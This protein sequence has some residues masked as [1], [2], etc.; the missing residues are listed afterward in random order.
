MVK[1]LFFLIFFYM[2]GEVSAQELK[3]GYYPDGKLRYKGYFVNE[4]PVGELIRYYPEGEVKARM[5]YRGDTVEAVLYSRNGEYTLMGKFLK[6]R[7]FGVWEYRKES[8]VI[9]CEEYEND[10]LDGKSVK[11]D[12]NGRVLE[13]KCWKQGKRE[14]EWSLFYDNGQ[15]R[16]HTFY[17]ADHLNGEMKTYSRNGQ[18]RAK[19]LYKDNLK[20]G[21][22]EFYDE[23][24]HLVVQQVYHAGITENAELQELEESRKLDRLIDSGKKIPDP[25]VFMD[26]PD[27]YMRLTGME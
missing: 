13:Q 25:A 21:K 8:Q 2:L 6:R 27:A 14:G 22:W 17:T 18:L 7:K 5:N 1:G 3:C 9:A 19:G 23:E 4:K 24:G 15:L 26:D 11:Y 12:L 10:L 20:E 16:F